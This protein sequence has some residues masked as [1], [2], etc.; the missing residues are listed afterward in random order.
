LIQGGKPINKENLETVMFRLAS[1]E[2]PFKPFE[3]R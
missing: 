3:M 2:H 1:T